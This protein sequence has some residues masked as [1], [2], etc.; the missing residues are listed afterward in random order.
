MAVF[1]VEKDKNYTVIAN[2]MYYNHQLSWKAKGILSNMLSLPEDW[3]YSME[4]LSKLASDGVVSTRS[5]LKE[6][7]EHGYLV[8]KPKKERGKIVDW[9]YDIY[10]VPRVE[11][12]DAEKP[13]PEKPDPEKPDPEKPD[14]EKSDM[15]NPE[16]EEPEVEELDLEK[17][18]QLN[19]DISNT[20]LSSKKNKE[21]KPS[22]AVFLPPTLEEV[23]A[24][25]IERKNGIDPQRFLDYYTST[26]WMVGRTKLYDWRAKIRTWESSERQGG[27][28]NGSIRK[29]ESD[30]GKSGADINW[31]MEY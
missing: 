18:G 10:E 21:S 22:Q 17:E 31:G 20:F 4:G 19:T 30:Q 24:Y 2:H 3:D 11:K 14:A 23:R 6:L 29:N 16:V 1:R 25:C 26:G 15:E 5:A 27:K 13:D 7:E 9:I 12:S 8:I 28:E